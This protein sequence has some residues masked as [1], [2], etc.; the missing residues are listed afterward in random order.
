VASTYRFSLVQMQMVVN[1]ILV[2]GL[3]RWRLLINC[4]CLSLAISVAQEDDMLCHVVVPNEVIRLVH[5]AECQDRSPTDPQ[6]LGPIAAKVN[7]QQ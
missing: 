1:W 7:C 5:A 6:T 4:G 3:I 2:I